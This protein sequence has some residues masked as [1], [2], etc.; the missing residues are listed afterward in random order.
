MRNT[1]LYSINDLKDRADAVKRII[2]IEDAYPLVSYKEAILQAAHVM[3]RIFA[4]R[5]STYLEDED[6]IQF[7]NNR[8]M[9][10]DIN[11]NIIC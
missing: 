7:I 10:F 6:V 1:K 9:W 11:G 2:S 3:R 4:M 5:D 8:D